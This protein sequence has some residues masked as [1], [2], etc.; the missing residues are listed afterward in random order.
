MVPLRI[1]D[2]RF[3]LG[4]N[5]KKAYLFDR[6]KD[7]YIDLGIGVNIIG[8]K[9]GENDRESSI[10]YFNPNIFKNAIYDKTTTFNGKPL[11][12]LIEEEI[13]TKKASNK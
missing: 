5:E 7:E 11:T 10:E 9:F 12:T 13:Q 3:L 8:C 6:V 4:T 1:Y 2:S